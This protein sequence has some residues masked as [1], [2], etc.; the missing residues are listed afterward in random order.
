MTIGTADETL[1]APWIVRLCAKE[2]PDRKKALSK[3]AVK[4]LHSHE[5]KESRAKFFSNSPYWLRNLC[6]ATSL[7]LVHC[8][9]STRCQFGVSFDRQR[10][11][12]G[13]HTLPGVFR[14]RAT[15]LAV[16]R[17]PKWHRELSGQ[18][19]RQL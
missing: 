11:A 16:E 19:T 14:R 17:R 12:Q 7:T 2:A 5:C 8:P 4:I 3:V 9:G 1:S 13:N 10:G 15:K 6:I 18:C